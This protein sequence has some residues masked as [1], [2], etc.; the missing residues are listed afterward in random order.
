MKIDILGTPFNGLSSPSGIENPAEGLRRA[1]VVPFLKANGHSVSDLGDLR[2]FQF[3]DIVDPDTGIKDFDL[4]IALSKGLA[5]A[6]DKMLSNKSFPLLLGGDCS[7]LVGILLAFAR[8]DRNVGLVFVDGHADFHSQETSKTGDPADMELAIV[9]G[10]GPDKITR[11]GP[12]YPLTIDDQV[13]VYGIRA[14]DN[15][16]D[17]TIRVFDRKRLKEIGIK[18]AVEKGTKDFNR[19]N[20]PVWVHFDVDVLDPEFMP[21]MFPEPGGLTFD[22]TR[23]L[24]S[25]VLA[26]ANAA[27]MSVA[28]YHPVLDADGWAGKQLAELIAEVLPAKS[29]R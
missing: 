20:L 11:I 17:T 12:K 23:E 8:R 4:W 2:G 22:E 28:C 24:V 9:T 3:Q 5:N 10:R 15:I 16:A 26:S 1:G 14:W 7:M 18:K 27:G 21:V 13:V 19:K 29:I 25:A 6:L